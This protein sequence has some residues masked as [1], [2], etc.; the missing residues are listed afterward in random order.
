MKH[1]RSILSGTAL[2]IAIFC[3]ADSPR[4]SY[5]A[6]EYPLFQEEGAEKCLL[7]NG[8]TLIIKEDRRT[9]TFAV[10]LYV[11]TGSSMED[12]YAG[13]GITHFIEHMIFKGS[14]NRNA[15][16]IEAELKLLGA[17]TEAYTTLD[18]TAFKMQGP[19]SNILPCLDIFY[20][21]TAN[22]KF[23]QAEFEKE[24]NVIKKEI[25]LVQDEPQK[26]LSQQ[27][28][29]AAYLIHP[30]RYPI[31]GYEDILDKLTPANLSDYYN[32]RYVP[33]S[34]VMVIVGDIDSQQVKRKIISLYGNL[35][36]KSSLSPTL[37]QEPPQLSYRYEEIPYATSK[38]YIIMGFHSVAM[39]SR[40]L[41]ALDTLAILLG[42]G[43][44]SI[45][46]QTLHNKL[47][48]VYD[49]GSSNYTPFNPGFFIISA[50]CD[51][52]KRQKIIKA[53]L[54]AIEDIKKTSLKKEELEK[55][56]NKVMSSYIF[57]R[58]TQEA[59]ADDLGINQ[60]LTAD[61]EF[62]KR[63][64]EGISSV[65]PKDIIEV[66]NKYLNKD[67]MT[68]LVLAP[69][70]DHGKDADLPPKAVP[71]ERVV[72]KKSLKNGIRLLI[73]QDKT[74]PLVSIRVIMNGGLRMENKENNGISNL[75]VHM[76]TKG[77]ASRSEEQIASAVEMLGGELS[78]YSANN[79]LGL[80]LDIMSKDFN[81]GIEILGDILTHPSFPEDKLSLLKKDTL[82]MIQLIDDDIYTSTEKRLR[83]KL[84]EGHPYGMLAI[85]TADSIGK[86]DRSRIISFYRACCV[87]SN[88]VVSICGDIDPKKAYEQIASKLEAIKKGK[89]ASL[90][91]AGL[92]A[93]KERVHITEKMD[94]K[95]ALVMIGFRSAGLNSPDRYSLHI[96]SSIFSGGAGRLF[97]SI[98][99]QFGLAYTVGT[100]GMAGTDTGSF[101]FYAA[102]SP[103]DVDFVKEEIIKQIR[104]VCEGDVTPEEM[105]SS[106]RL[107]IS[108]HQINLQSAGSFALQVALDELYG[109]GFD[110]YQLYADKI[111]KLSREEIIQTA[112][113]YL[114]V[115]NCVVS[116]TTPKDNE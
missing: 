30:Y 15:Q 24:K 113:K 84:F 16:Q 59:Q 12:E 89:P 52:E 61:M 68:T 67:N 91:E 37:P 70:A 79:S 6:T 111:N 75:V 23:D 31:I 35:A 25:K 69:S 85:G 51:Y 77:T 32:K 22:P 14:A 58:Q 46:Y 94:K 66:A 53:V 110:N 4:I 60:L 81:N 105:D 62:S 93:I 28:W 38:T 44:S 21:I 27:F 64:I 72:I 57:N 115:D 73:C 48:L 13:S 1:G 90:P 116:V 108:R 49:I 20:D 39:L 7:N 33:A 92:Q 97:A 101:V 54:D 11:K 78:S 114:T 103:P 100:F 42:E 88:I 96:L 43:H 3:L 107:L 98:R 83:E 8:L 106:K 45:L 74:L 99:Q 50:T 86:I 104:I 9:P 71:A 17:D 87:G 40:D 76:L 109:L 5:A 26:Y 102:V 65:T 47:N 63:Y 18:Y 55:A 19:G 36:R 80:S 56:K 10:S 2:L 95:Q 29:Q 112:N 34:M 41:Y 82:A